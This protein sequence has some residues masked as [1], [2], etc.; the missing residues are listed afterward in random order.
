MFD[1]ENQCPVSN[2]T[3]KVG[4]SGNQ[5]VDISFTMNRPRDVTGVTDASGYVALKVSSYPAWWEI[6]APGYLFDSFGNPEEHNRSSPHVP[7]SVAVTGEQNTADVFLYRE[8]RPLLNIDVPSNYRG[9]LRVIASKHLD[10]QTPKQSIREFTFQATKDGCCIIP[11]VEI[12]KHYRPDIHLRC[13]GE[14]IYPARRSEP[15]RAY[16]HGIPYLTPKAM[17]W[18]FTIGDQVDYE[19]REV[20]LW[21]PGLG[22]SKNPNLDEYHRL[23]GF[24]ICSE[25]PNL[26]DLDNAS[27]SP[28]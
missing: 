5:I 8:P 24:D 1:A 6:T 14:R 11:L 19:E 3:V 13:D 10:F 26:L 18:L 16:R 28:R 12:M 20:R 27:R 25:L 9:P 7:R 2:A 21:S 15:I 4:Y 22:R 23:F 17:L